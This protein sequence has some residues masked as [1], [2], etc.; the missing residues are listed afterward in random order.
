MLVSVTSVIRILA[1]VALAMSTGC[2]TPA[3]E[4][5]GERSEW[6]WDEPAGVPVRLG[7]LP[8]RSPVAPPRGLGA[9]S[10]VT[11]SKDGTLTFVFQTSMGEFW[12]TQRPTDRT[13]LPGMVPLCGGR[14]E[15]TLHRELRGVLIYGESTR[16][17]TWFEGGLRIQVVG[18]NADLTREEAIQIAAHVPAP[19]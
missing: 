11:R 10:S 18:D 2:A 4:P 1:I 15:L 14:E 5:C 19:S 9:P 6:P 17:L 16:Y 7:D 12:I 3:E 13:Q 8:G